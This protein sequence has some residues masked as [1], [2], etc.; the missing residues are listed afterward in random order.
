MIVCIMLFSLAIISISCQKEKKELDITEI[1]IKSQ[2]RADKYFCKDILGIAYNKNKPWLV[3]NKFIKD[4][5]LTSIL[6]DNY[7]DSSW[8]FYETRD[9]F[10]IKES[11]R[12]KLINEYNSIYKEK[13]E[14]YL[15]RLNQPMRNNKGMYKTYVWINANKWG[16][17]FQV[18]VEYY[19]KDN[20]AKVFYIYEV[21]SSNVGGAPD[22]EF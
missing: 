17:G 3:Y 10:C 11:K 16:G 5:E 21:I 15:V 13:N 4:R 14:Y 19:V 6:A 20:K 1:I 7:K 18:Y 12:N 9:S 22:P 2:E 8:I